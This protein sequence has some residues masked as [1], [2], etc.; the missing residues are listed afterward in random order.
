MGSLDTHT[1]LD[2]P[3][4]G[5]SSFKKFFFIPNHLSSLFLSLLSLSFSLLSV[6]LFSSLYIFLSLSYLFII[7]L[8]FSLYHPFSFSLF[9]LSI[10][11][12]YFHHCLSPIFLLSLFH[13]LFTNQFSDVTLRPKI[14]VSPESSLLVEDS[15]PSHNFSLNK[16]KK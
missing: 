4:L 16:G 5:T 10:S 8:S 2:N 3:L 6:S 14:S 12:F 15:S 7:S 11:C 13:S 1:P 9:T